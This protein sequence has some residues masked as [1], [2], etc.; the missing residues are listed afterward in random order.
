MPASAKPTQGK[1]RPKGAPG[2][3]RPGSRPPQTRGRQPR[4]RTTAQG[5]RAAAR[6]E[7]GRRAAEELLKLRPLLKDVGSALVGRLDGERAG[8]ARALNGG[9]L[10]GEPP[11]LPKASVLAAMLADL[12]TL[13]LKPKKGRVKDLRRIEALLDSLSARLPPGA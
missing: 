4:P 7:L 5:A 3:G 2:D 12:Q 10:P 8:L 9:G 13:K 11:V 6:G 1:T